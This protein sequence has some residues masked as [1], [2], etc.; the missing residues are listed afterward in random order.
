[1][2]WFTAERQV[3]NASVA[4]AAES[5]LGFPAWQLALTMQQFYQWRGFFHDWKN[6]METVLRAAERDTDQPGQGHVLRSLA[7]ACFYLSQ[8]DEALRYL[9]RAQAIYTALGYDTEHAYLHSSFGQVFTHQGRQ[10]LA[11]EHNQKALELYRE[12]G[13]RRGEARAIADIGSAHSALGDYPAAVSHLERG[14]ALAQEI[15]KPH[16]EGKVRKD[17]GVVRSKLGQQD[18]A[19]EQLGQALALIRGVGDRPVEAETLLALGDALAAQGHK[20]A[21]GDAWRQASLIFSAFH[22]DDSAMRPRWNRSAE[23]LR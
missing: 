17:L 16:Q 19:V 2:S 18:K 3:L 8:P 22:Q 10:Q 11:I 4:L 9:K 21:A 15:G 13:D 12:A 1:M 5:D 7:E 20:D 6:T 23:N 14:I